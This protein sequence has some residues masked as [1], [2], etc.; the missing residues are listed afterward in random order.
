MKRLGIVWRMLVVGPA[1]GVLG[2]VRLGDR[3]E[4]ILIP[5]SPLARFEESEISTFVILETQLVAPE[6]VL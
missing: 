6:L 4:G 3:E 1:L 5:R 2:E